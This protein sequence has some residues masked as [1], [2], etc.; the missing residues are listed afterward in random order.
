MRKSNNEGGTQF[1][2]PNTE[3]LK[4]QHHI[5]IIHGKLFKN[6][7]TIVVLQKNLIILMSL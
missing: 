7:S 5:A 2:Q 6:I 3:N 1:N 4:E